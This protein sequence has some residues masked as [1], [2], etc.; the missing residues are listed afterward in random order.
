MR[1]E[2]VRGAGRARARRAAGGARSILIRHVKRGERLV[3]QQQPRVGHQ[4]AG[5]RHALLPGRRTSPRAW[6]RPPRRGQGGVS[7]PAAFAACRRPVGALASWQAERHVLQ[8]AQVREEQV[9]LEHRRRRW[10][11][12]GAILTRLPGSSST[13]CRRGRPG[14]RP[15]GAV[16]SGPAAA[17][18]LAR[19]V[20][21]E[22][23]QHLPGRHGERGVQVEGAACRCRHDVRFERH[24]PAP[25]GT[26]VSA[27]PCHRSR[28]QID[29]HEADQDEDR[30]S[31]RSPRRV[32]FELWLM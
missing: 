7:S 23:G 13:P 26:A 2:H 25:E 29:D 14:R 20:G 18:D 10:A 4:R 28:Q 17:V 12:D 9:V 16:P 1:D 21:T 8:G 3:Q 11:L 15:A 22:Q 31:A 6:P 19:A 27:G 24:N 30:G 5:H 32:W